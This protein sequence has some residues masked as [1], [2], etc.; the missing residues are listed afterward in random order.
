MAHHRLRH[1]IEAEKSSETA[2]KIIDQVMPEK[3]GE[4]SKAIAPDWIPMQMLLR[5][6]EA[7]LKSENHQV[8]TTNN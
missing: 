5:E 6:A 4:R 8:T 1:S 3:P 2:R 7:L